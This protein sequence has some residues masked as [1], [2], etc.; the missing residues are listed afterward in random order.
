MTLLGIGLA[1]YFG[2]LAGSGQGDRSLMFLL[3][4]V[5]LALIIQMKARIW[6][7][8]P[9]C[10]G[11]QGNLVGLP[12]PFSVRDLAIFMA[13]GAFLV[14]KALKIVNRKPAFNFIDFLLLVNLLMLLQAFIRNPTGTNAMGSDRVGGRPYVEVIIALMAYWVLNRAPAT[15][16]MF[17]TAIKGLLVAAGLDTAL[18][19]LATYF[20]SIGIS[21]SRIYFNSTFGIETSETGTELQ[22]VAQNEEI[23][24]RECYL[25]QIAMPLLLF[26]F[27]KYLPI[28]LVNPLYIGRF[29]LFLVGIVFLFAAGFRS[30][31]FE[32]ANYFL[33]SSYFKKGMARLLPLLGIVVLILIAVSFLNGRLFKLPL[34]AQRVL[35]FLPGNWNYDAVQAAKSSSEWRFE[36][37]RRE[38]GGGWLEGNKYLHNKIIG[39]GFGADRVLF[40]QGVIASAGDPSTESQQENAAIMGDVHSGPIS[41]IRAVGYVGL[42]LFL[43]F[44][45]F[46]ARYAWQLII[47][48]KG[49]PYELPTLFFGMPMIYMPVGF[50]FIFGAYYLDLPTLIIG[51]GILKLLNYGLNEYNREKQAAAPV[52]LQNNATQFPVRPALGRI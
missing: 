10:A 40:E 16:K 34:P 35:S 29:I 38:M 43:V 8:I 47:K 24:S 3:G 22:Q 32:N 9:I 41:T 48:A 44:L 52:V 25:A 27:S 31:F 46:L 50:P 11:I 21:I 17:S 36:I 1:L 15:P 7:L 26:L 6:L 30:R 33:L 14:F 51:L 49:T 2:K 12:L 37:W 19:A 4:F 42:I 23:V 28:T 5:A 18:C 45:V 13:F 39:D 20:P